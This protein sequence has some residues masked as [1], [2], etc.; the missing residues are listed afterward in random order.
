MKKIQ[1]EATMHVPHSQR[2][3]F[4]RIWADRSNARAAKPNSMLTMME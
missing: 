2:V 3:G 1:R 4:C